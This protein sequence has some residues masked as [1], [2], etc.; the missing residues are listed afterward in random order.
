MKMS[1]FTFVAH[2]LPQVSQSYADHVTAKKANGAND[3]AQQANKT[4]CLDK[5]QELP[6]LSSE[7]MAKLIRMKKDGQGQA[8]IA[9]ALG[10][11][12]HEVRQH[13]EKIQKRLNGDGDK[14]QTGKEIKNNGESSKA[15][16][17]KKRTEKG[18]G[19]E[20]EFKIKAPSADKYFSSDNVRPSRSK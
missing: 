8:K 19:T 1:F 6:D 4:D 12:K 7:Q 18:W 13:W 20:I 17:K 9:T 10:I 14:P 5:S 11:S 16:D 15:N 3:T 2:K